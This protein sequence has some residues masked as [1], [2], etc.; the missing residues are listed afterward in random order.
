MEFPFNRFSAAVQIAIEVDPSSVRNDY[1]MP[2]MSIFY[3]QQEMQ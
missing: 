3:I 2:Q 1:I